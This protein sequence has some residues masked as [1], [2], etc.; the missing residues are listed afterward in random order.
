MFRAVERKVK[1]E[2]RLYAT[3][4]IVNDSLDLCAKCILSSCYAPK[5]QNCC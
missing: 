1:F 5:K 2:P 4:K 3:L